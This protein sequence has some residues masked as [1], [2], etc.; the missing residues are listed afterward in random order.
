VAT[1]RIVQTPV[2]APVSIRT[3]EKIGSV[4]VVVCRDRHVELR[5]P[6]ELS[7]GGAIIGL[8]PI[9]WCLAAWTICLH[10]HVLRERLG[11]CVALTAI[12][13]VSAMLMNSCLGVIWRFDGRKLRITRRVGLLGRGH[14]ARRL[15]GLKVESTRPSTMA[16]VHLRMTLIDAT[17]QEQFEIA[18]WKRREIDRAQ[19]D[20]LAAAIRKA[21]NWVEE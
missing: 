17:G 14:N 5:T 12:A 9:V 2:D 3:G 20:G 1:E 11:G 7:W 21:M 8:V 19:V 10:E 15:A 13:A 16:D 4:R 6:S 18:S